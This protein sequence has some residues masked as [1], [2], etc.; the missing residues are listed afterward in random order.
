[1]QPCHT[2]HDLHMDPRASNKMPRS[3]SSRG[4]PGLRSAK[5]TESAAGPAG[6]PD[7]PDRGACRVLLANRAD[8][9]TVMQF[10]N[11]NL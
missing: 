8:S 10:Y 6:V 9:P 3:T 1:M 5:Q 2:A 4:R 7:R 11:L